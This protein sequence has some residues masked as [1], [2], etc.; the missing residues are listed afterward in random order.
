MVY[1]VRSASLSEMVL[2]M[3]LN[4]A[5]ISPITKSQTTPSQQHS[6]PSN[7]DPGPSPTSPTSRSLTT[8]VSSASG[9]YQLTVF[10][11]RS[12]VAS[13]TSPATA[14]P[15]TS[16]LTDVGSTLCLLCE[17]HSTPGLTDTAHLLLSLLTPCIVLLHLATK[18]SSELCLNFHPLS[19][20]TS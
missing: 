8:C 7:Y 17:T 1:F 15:H 2:T 11:V 3:V 10:P 14:A 5:Q 18:Y 12:S 20:G 6:L 13:I 16:S 19:L 9:S 4:N